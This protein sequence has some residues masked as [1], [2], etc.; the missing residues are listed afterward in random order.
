MDR[1]GGWKRSQ[2]GQVSNVRAARYR[3]RRQRMVEVTSRVQNLADSVV[4]GVRQKDGQAS[5][6]LSRIQS[7]GSG[8]KQRQKQEQE[9]RIQGTGAHGK[10]TPRP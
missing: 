6:G 4:Q 10:H 9:Y 2:A 5:Q 8:T 3:R 1:L 7:A